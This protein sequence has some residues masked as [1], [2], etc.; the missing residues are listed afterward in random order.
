MDLAVENKKIRHLFIYTF[1]LKSRDTHNCLSLHA[2]FE[3]A[4]L[5][6]ELSLPESYA[7]RLANGRR[8]AWKLSVLLGKENV[9]LGR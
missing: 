1:C 6:H 3:M 7:D 2:P 5:V 4:P 9:F 8:R